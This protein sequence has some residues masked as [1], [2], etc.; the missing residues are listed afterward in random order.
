METLGTINP[1][2][3]AQFVEALL[4]GDKRVAADITQ[5]LLDDDVPIREIYLGLF[6]HALYRVGALW[7]RNRISVATEHLATSITLS[8]FHLVYP[9][10]FST[11]RR[12]RVAVITCTPGELHLVG[13]RMIA[14]ICELHGWDGHFI[15]ADSPVSDLCRLV[16]QKQP[17]LLA[18]S[19]T[20]YWNAPVL[21]QLLREIRKVN[22][23]VPIIVGGQAITHGADTL[24]ADVP[25]VLPIRTLEEFESY[26]DKH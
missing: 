15:G 13:A 2:L 12:G 1:T 3:S 26:L 17:H 9:R 19:I 6:Q 14:D 4:A 24:L 25:D 20:L 23:A 11:P 18:V 8:L 22:P 21:L 7:E 10:L 16:E 5:S